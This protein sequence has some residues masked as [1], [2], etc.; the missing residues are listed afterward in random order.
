MRP[1]SS[2]SPPTANDLPG[3]R[4]SLMYGCSSSI[5]PHVREMISRTRSSYTSGRRRMASG[6]PA[7]LVRATAFASSIWRRVK[8]VIGSTMGTGIETRSRGK[9]VC[10]QSV[11]RWLYAPTPVKLSASTSIELKCSVWS[12]V[13][14]RMKPRSGAAHPSPITCSQ[15]TST[16]VSGTAGSL[17]ASASLAGS[18]SAGTIR[19]MCSPP[20][21]T[22]SPLPAS[23]W[24][25]RMPRRCSSVTS[26]ST[27][28]SMP[29]SW[30]FSTTSALSG[31]SYGASIPVKPL[32]SPL[33]TL[34]YSPFGSRAFTTSSGTS[35][36]TSRKGIPRFRCISRAASRSLRY[37]EMSVTIE[38][39][40][41]SAKSAE[42]SAAR[43]TDS[44]RSSGEKPKSRVS[45]VR[46]LSPSM[47]N[48]FLPIASSSFFSSALQIVVLPAPDSPV[49]HSVTPFCPSTL[50]RSSAPIRHFCPAS[51]ST[52]F[53][54]GRASMSARF[55]PATTASGSFSGH[56]GASGA[57]A[58]GHSSVHA[59]QGGH[60]VGWRE[61]QAGQAL[62]CGHLERAPSIASAISRLDSGMHLAAAESAMS[63]GSAHGRA[64]RYATMVMSTPVANERNIE[65]RHRLSMACR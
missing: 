16:S 50:N 53:F 62:H 63:C 48:T 27:H 17:A 28:L 13:P 37:G 6:T 24:P 60:D 47:L 21:G 4:S 41:D 7:A 46:R 45:P 20:S 10:I 39:R 36:N 52:M 12:S 5:T 33:A 29:I 55:R 25:E 30:F 64:T 3:E 9:V 32:I 54:I 14:S 31:A 35:M 65:R 51:H 43:R 19:L 56:P 61:G 34:A 40:P 38:M 22:A 44:A 1:S 57:S 2:T 58:F 11:S 15:F 8:S 23:G 59:G 49:I 42:T 18:S 26:T